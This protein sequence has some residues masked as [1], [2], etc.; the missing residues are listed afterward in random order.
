[1]ERRPKQD[2]PISK[3]TNSIKNIN[4]A[5]NRVNSMKNLL[6]ISSNTGP[7]KAPP[8]RMKHLLSM[9]LVRFMYSPKAKPPAN[10][11]C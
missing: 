7:H 8:K 1:M 5:P 2:T 9:A 3:H 10:R 11:A 6:Q 4:R